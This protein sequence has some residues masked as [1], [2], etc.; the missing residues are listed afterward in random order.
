MLESIST[1]RGFRAGAAI[2][3]LLLV[4]RIG[5]GAE[6]KTVPHRMHPQQPSPVWVADGTTEYTLYIYLDNTGLNGQPTH[7]AQWKLTSIN[8]LQYVEGSSAAPDINDF[9]ANYPTREDDIFLG[10]LG[11]SSRIV[12][13]I[14]T[15]PIDYQGCLGMYRFRV[16]TNTAPGTYHFDLTSNTRIYDIDFNP[17]P[18]ILTYEL[19]W[20][21]P[22]NPADFHSPPEISRDGYIDLPPVYVPVVM[23]VEPSLRSSGGCSS[24]ALR[25]GLRSREFGG[26]APED[27]Q[28]PAN[29]AGVW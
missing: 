3:G 4:T 10:P 29:A 13:E 28:R 1:R 23:R 18:R 5:S 6:I 15:G 12:E 16:P 20:I 7:A 25:M 9:F 24:G 8:G 2:A 27:R 21:A 14:G 11:L 22:I 17:Q 26:R 19:V